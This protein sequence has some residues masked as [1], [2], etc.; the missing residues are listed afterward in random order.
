MGVL[1][2]TAS[3]NSFAINAYCIASALFFSA[4]AYAQLNDP[5]PVQWFCA[6][7]FGGTVPNLY[8]MTTAG[9][10][11]VADAMTMTTTR[12]NL[13]LALHGFVA[14]MGL[15]I[16]YKLVT[17]A[18]KL[19]EDV[20][21][22]HHGLLWAFMEHEEGRDSC[23]LLLLILHVSYLNSVLAVRGS[24]GGEGSARAGRS[25]AGI[26]PAVVAFALFGVLGVSV[27]VWIVHHPDLVAKHRLKHCQGEM[28]GRAAGEL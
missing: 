11:G 1:N 9:D 27:Y 23:G 12:R 13:V 15:A 8:W 14:G 3:V 26:P 25:S 6:Y 4:C 21:R 5:N 16:V 28:F 22:Y 19:L 7:V 18:P 2:D 24:G 10:G 20:S 17:L